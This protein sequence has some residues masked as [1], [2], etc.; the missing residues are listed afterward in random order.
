MHEVNVKQHQ[1]AVGKVSKNNEYL[2]T[3]GLW[4]C[5]GW[6]GWD[7]ENQVAFLCHFDHPQ[8]SNSVSEI[9]NVISEYVPKNHHFESI[10]I[11]G[12]GWLLYS[13]LT[14]KKIIH[15]VNSQKIVN[16]SISETPFNNWFT[17][18]VDVSICLKTGV[19]SMAKVEG[20]TRPKGNTWL[21]RPMERVILT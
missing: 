12:K 4:S 18:V 15:T 19:L 8:S 13:R 10:L 7:K 5:T 17:S 20:E 6:V 11:G 21:F 9:L 14:R 1:F 16:I 3:K 2:A